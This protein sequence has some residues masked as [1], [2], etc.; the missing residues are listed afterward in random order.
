MGI[1]ENSSERLNMSDFNSLNEFQKKSFLI[2]KNFHDFCLKNDLKYCL[3]GGSALGAIRHQGFIPWDDDIDV[4][5]PRADYDRLIKIVKEISFP[6]AGDFPEIDDEFYLDFGKIYD[7]STTVIEDTPVKLKRG[8]WID[9][10]PLDGAFEEGY[11]RSIHLFLIDFI[12]NLLKIKRGITIK[13]NRGWMKN[14]I[15]FITHGI[16]SLVKIEKIVFILNYILKFKEINKS[17]YISNYLGRWGIREI[18]DRR[19]YFDFNEHHFVD[20][21]YPVPAKLHEYLIHMYG[22]YLT[23]PDIDKRSSGHEFLEINLNKSFYE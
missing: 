11:K 1:F 17:N 16:L 12:R 22:D 21:N 6:F 14:S 7:T 15:F 8:V 3:L 23:P 19:N 9:V 13:K 10:F 20:A 2:F 5:L 4:G 18:Q